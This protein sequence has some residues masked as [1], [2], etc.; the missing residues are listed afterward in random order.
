MV[1]RLDLE[2]DGQS[3]ANV[4]DAGVFLPCADEDF[5]RLGRERVEQRAGALV[6]AML[7]PHHGEDAEFGVIG[8]AS[9]DF[10]DALVF[11]R[12]QAVLFDQLGSDGGIGHG[13]AHF[14]I[15]QPHAASAA[16]L[17]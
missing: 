9:E 14:H 7:A 2:R 6:V 3:V 10:L 1:V 5:F 16:V 4:D 17:P 12:R 15:L 13:L 11:L 8:L